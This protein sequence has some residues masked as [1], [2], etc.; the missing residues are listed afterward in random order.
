M[1]YEKWRS[2][3]EK[4]GE[5]KGICARIRARENQGNNPANNAANWIKDI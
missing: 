1:A 2:W 4:E 3:R 5:G